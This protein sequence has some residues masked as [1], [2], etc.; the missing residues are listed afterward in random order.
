MIDE[1]SNYNLI[2]EQSYIS[3]NSYAKN[4][5]LYFAYDKSNN[6]IFIIIDN[7]LQ[8]IYYK[9][10]ISNL[11]FDSVCGWFFTDDWLILSTNKIINSEQLPDFFGYKHRNEKLNNILTKM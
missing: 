7:E 10:T 5:T 8:N 3:T 4:Y 2:V 1:L 9:T 11:D 6:I